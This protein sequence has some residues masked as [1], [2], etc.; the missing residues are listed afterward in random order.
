MKWASLYYVELCLKPPAW[1]YGVIYAVS[2]SLSLSLRLGLQRKHSPLLALSLSL[3]PSPS[4]SLY[5]HSLSTQC[6]VCLTNDRALP[7][8]RRDRSA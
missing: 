4:L 5:T 2:A 8:G 6:A 7:C 1:V 3:S